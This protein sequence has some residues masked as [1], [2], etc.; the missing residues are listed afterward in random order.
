MRFSIVCSPSDAGASRARADC[1]NDF[2]TATIVN[3]MPPNLLAHYLYLGE[4]TLVQQAIETARTSVSSGGHSS[5]YWC[6]LMYEKL[7]ALIERHTAALEALVELLRDRLP[8]TRL[9]LFTEEDNETVSGNH[10][11]PLL[12]RARRHAERRPS[13][14]PLHDMLTRAE[15]LARDAKIDELHILLQH[16]D[17]LCGLPPDDSEK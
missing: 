11:E 5:S 14:D 7:L 1:V 17:R 8:H 2:A 12:A 6:Q 15:Q 16:I 13:H 4:T 10:P 3:G 9:N